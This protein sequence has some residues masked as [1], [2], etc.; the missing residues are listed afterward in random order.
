MRPCW[1]A[2]SHLQT[3]QL[4]CDQ[5]MGARQGLGLDIQRGNQLLQHSSISERA[6]GS[7]STENALHRRKP[8]DCKDWD[9]ALMR[10]RAGEGHT[11]GPTGLDPARGLTLRFLPDML[12]ERLG[13]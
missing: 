10:G 7:V 12:T 11:R 2:E 3:L 13:L 4:V 1:S 8:R 9:I 6:A 5:H